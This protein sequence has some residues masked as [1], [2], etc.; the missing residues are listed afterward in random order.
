MLL[1][2]M[3]AQHTGKVRP[4]ICPFIECDHKLADD[5]VVTHVSTAHR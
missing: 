5:A 4:I 3:L 2:H 1:S